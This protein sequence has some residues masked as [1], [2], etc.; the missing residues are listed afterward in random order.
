MYAHCG[1]IFLQ[2][3]RS[4]TCILSRVYAVTM[5]TG[6]VTVQGLKN[7]FC[8]L[9]KIQ[10]LDFFHHL[11]TKNAH[12]NYSYQHCSN[13]PL[14]ATV[15]VIGRKWFSPHVLYYQKNPIVPLFD[16]LFAYFLINH[17]F[18]KFLE[19]PTTGSIV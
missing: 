15:F 11:P 9:K 4:T 6:L 14:T 16:R 3:V 1:P 8:C 12:K 5:A 17:I 18:A 10:S 13:K 19:I 2:E 7:V